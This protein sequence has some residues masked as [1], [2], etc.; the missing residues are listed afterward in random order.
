MYVPYV[1]P[2]HVYVLRR[3]HVGIVEDW[4]YTY[5]GEGFQ[6]KVDLILFEVHVISTSPRTARRILA[7][8]LPYLPHLVATVG[9]FSL[10]KE[11]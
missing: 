9:F 5:K 8:M 1:C 2:V 4:L 6:L 11:H 10:Q 7:H 3:F